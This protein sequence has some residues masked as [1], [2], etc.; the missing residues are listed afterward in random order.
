MSSCQQLGSRGSY[1]DACVYKS[2][3]GGIHIVYTY[4]HIP[5]SG[6]SSCT[7]TD[8]HR[9]RPLLSVLCVSVLFVS[10]FICAVHCMYT[11]KYSADMFVY[12]PGVPRE[13]VLSL[14]TRWTWGHG[15]VAALSLSSCQIWP[16]SPNNNV[17]SKYLFSFYL[18]KRAQL[19]K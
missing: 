13:Y 7:A 17:L 9:M 5:T 12:V 1:W 16:Y 15:S 14:T 4:I 8:T 11:C 3:C 10:V 19:W 2:S 6:P 18:G